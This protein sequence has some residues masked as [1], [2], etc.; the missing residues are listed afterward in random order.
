MLGGLVAENLVS[1]S[2]Y[3]SI[4]VRAAL[5]YLKYIYVCVEHGLCA[6]AHT[7]YFLPVVVTSTVT[8]EGYKRG[9]TESRAV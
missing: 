2:R 1:G 7:S 9:R 6:S 8:K 4:C 3:V 5:Q